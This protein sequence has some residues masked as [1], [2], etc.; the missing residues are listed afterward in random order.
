MEQNIRLPKRPFAKDGGVVVLA[1]RGWRGY[2]PENTMLS[3][4]WA[5]HMPIDGLELDIH[6]TKDGELVVIHDETVDRTTNGKGRVQDYSLAELQKL[7]AGYWWTPDEG[8]TFPFRGS[9][10]RI[11]TVEEVF[12]RFPNLWINIDIKQKSPSIVKAICRSDS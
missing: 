10:L 9:Q 11:P 4:D 6:S 12:K 2:Y 8:Q 1:H 7:D 3:L 5:G